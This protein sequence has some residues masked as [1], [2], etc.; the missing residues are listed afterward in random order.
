MTFDE[1]L[2]ELGLTTTVDASSARR[3]Y[4]KLIKTRKPE[5]DPEGFQRAREAWERIASQL[6]QGARSVSLAVAPLTPAAPAAGGSL[7]DNVAATEDDFRAEFA[8]LPPGTSVEAPLAI[9]RRAV[10]QLPDSQEAMTWL[11]RA[12]LSADRQPEAIDQLRAASSRFP[13]ALW[14][15]AL[16]FPASLSDPELQALGDSAPTGLLWKLADAFCSLDL[17]ERASAV[18]LLAFEAQKREPSAPPPP[19]GWIGMLVLRLNEAGQS[20]PARLIAERYDRWLRDSDLLDTFVRDPVGQVWPQL[21]EL[22]R[23]SDAL[24]PL[25]RKPLARAISEGPAGLQHACAEFARLFP[26]AAEEAHRALLDRAPSLMIAFRAQLAALV[27]APTPA[28]RRS[29]SRVLGMLGGLALLVFYLLNRGSSGEARPE[30]IMY[31]TTPITRP[32]IN[33]DILNTELKLIPPRP[34][35]QGKR[36]LLDEQE[37]VVGLSEPIAELPPS[38]AARATPGDKDGG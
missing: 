4:L 34:S 8:A 15:L 26:M 31:P 30:P 2:R 13:Q 36:S 11:V 12:L 6:E 14:N 18:A 10:A 24:P 35:A 33:G 27:L 29:P 7:G 1:A 3:A 32:R 5:S 22:S 19:P 16:W 9:A 25:L 20:A 28:V 17:G 38:K 21:V 23:L 37:L